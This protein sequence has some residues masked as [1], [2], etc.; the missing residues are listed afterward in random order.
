MLMWWGFPGDI[1]ASSVPVVQQVMMGFITW[2]LFSVV[3]AL[4]FVAV[5]IPM[6]DDHGPQ[7][8]SR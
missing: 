7:S 2:C 4:V 1:M 6:H 5:K 3:L 8:A